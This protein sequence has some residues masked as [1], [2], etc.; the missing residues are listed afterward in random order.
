MEKSIHTQH[1]KKLQELLRQVRYE[2]NLRQTEL[3]QKLDEPQSFVSKYENG[4]RRLDILEIREVCMAIGIPLEEFAR[5]LE[6]CLHQE[7]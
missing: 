3:A 6:D 4:E 5:R 1:Q 7:E 2:A